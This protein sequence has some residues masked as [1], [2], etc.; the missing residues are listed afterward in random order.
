[1]YDKPALLVP[2]ERDR[3]GERARRFPR[4]R[5][6]RARRGGAARR[7]CASSRRRTIESIAVCL[8]FSFLHPQHE[9]RVREIVARGDAGL[10]DLAVVGDVAADPRVLPALARRSST[11]TCSRSSR[12][13]SRSSSS[14]WPAPASRRGRNT[15]C[16]RTAAW[17]RSTA[18]RAK[19]VDD[20]AVRARRRRHRRRLCLPHDRLP[21]PHH[22]RHGR[23][24]VRRRADQGRRAL[25]RQPRQDRRPRHRACR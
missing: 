23:H 7:P 1:M 25:G 20:G 9:E 18:P 3:R 2:A 6:A 16:S 12:A 14:A 11:P 19:A 15:S 24:L 22:L 5:A 17:R 21:E 8:L 4:Q 10:R 13:T